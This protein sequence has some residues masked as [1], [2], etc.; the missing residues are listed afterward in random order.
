MSDLDLIVIGDANPDL[1]ITGD[2]LVPEFG[3]VEK[4]IERA[5]LVVGGSA[6]ITAI[7]AARLGLRVAICSVIGDD[8]AGRFMEASLA[9]AGVD[10]RYLR[11]DSSLPTGMSIIFMR[12]DDRA[13][14][15]APGTIDAVGADDLEHLPDVPA[16]HVHVASYFLTGD[17]FRSALPAALRRFRS[18]GVTT[19]IDTNWD[20]QERW[21]L[22]PVLDTIDLFLPNEAEVKAVAGRRSVEEAM[23]ALASGGPSIVVKRGSEGA[24][25]L[26]GG[27]WTEAGPPE[28]DEFVDAVGAGDSFNAGYLA[29]ILTGSEPAGALRLA[30]AAGTL[31]TRRTGGTGGQATREEA[32][33][34]ASSIN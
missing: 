3:Q 29:G 30:L 19:S 32:D 17:G 34:L 20:P 16:R 10:T 4:I 21:N 9:G 28:F 24:V 27:V 15:T 11:V 13:I 1:I 33:A 2:D 23:T 5:D 18:A 25:A 31:S 26:V 22:G 8:A 12:G 14:L 6:S 7:G